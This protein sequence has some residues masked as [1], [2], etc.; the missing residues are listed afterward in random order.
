MLIARGLGDPGAVRPALVDRVLDDRVPT[1]AA[2][3]DVALAVL[4]VDP[5]VARS[6]VE[7]VLP[8]APDDGVRAGTALDAIVA[9]VAVEAV[10]PREAGEVVGAGRPADRVRPI[11][12]PAR[13]A[14]RARVVA[15][16]D[17]H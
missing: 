7:D 15:G 14:R 8:L 12:H 2:V 16:G 11:R 6:P 4:R 10:G 5:V 13:L 3:D 17:D 9:V 1:P